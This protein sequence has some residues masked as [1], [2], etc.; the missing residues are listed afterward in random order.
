MSNMDAVNVKIADLTHNMDLS[1]LRVVTYQDSK[2]L[3]PTE[4]TML[5]FNL[6]LFTLAAVIW[7]RISAEFKLHGFRVVY[8]PAT[9]AAIS[10]FGIVNAITKIFIP[11]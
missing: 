6:T 2:F 5:Y 4:D 8:L 1:K 10:I 3:Q 9:I 7:L 11:I